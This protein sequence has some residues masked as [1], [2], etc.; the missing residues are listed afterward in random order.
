M[1]ANIIFVLFG[2]S[3]LYTVQ[4]NLDV[5]AVR[6]WELD[7]ERTRERERAHGIIMRKRKM[8]KSRTNN[9]STC[10][11]SSGIFVIQTTRNLSIFGNDFIDLFSIFRLLHV[12]FTS[13]IV[14]LRLLSHT[15]QKIPLQQCFNKH[16]WLI[17]VHFNQ[18]SNLSYAVYGMHIIVSQIRCHSSTF[19]TALVN[20]NQFVLLQN[21]HHFLCVCVSKWMLITN[22]D[23][24][25]NKRAQF[26]KE[27][28]AGRMSRRKTHS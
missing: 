25:E 28:Q 9:Y 20:I 21:E 18:C 10:M 24:T 23:G 22:T 11:N 6:E 19:D 12:Q 17:I 1:M 7:R 14:S 8:H 27:M 3:K 26:V 16:S 15:T 13:I 5:K 4:S 2:T